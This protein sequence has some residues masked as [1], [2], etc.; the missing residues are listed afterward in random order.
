[1]ARNDSPNMQRVSLLSLT[2]FT[3]ALTLLWDSMGEFLNNNTIRNPA[4]FFFFFL[5]VRKGFR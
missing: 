4:T 3:L 1:M 2:N 5:Q